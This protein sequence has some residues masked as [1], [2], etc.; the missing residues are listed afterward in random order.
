MSMSMSIGMNRVRG[1]VRLLVALSLFVGLE[2]A[3]PDHVGAQPRS[4]LKN[5]AHS[6]G[7][8]LVSG[9]C[10][11]RLDKAGLPIWRPMNQFAKDGLPELKHIVA[12]HFGWLNENQVAV[13][14][15]YL[16]FQKPAYGD[17]E[18]EARSHP[19][20]AN[21]CNADLR[22]VHL[23]DADLIR[24][25]LT[26]ANLSRANLLNANL[27]DANLYSANLSSAILQANMSGAHLSDANLSRAQLAGANL[28]RADLSEANLNRA[29][30]G[31][32]D[33]NGADVT[34][35]DLSHADLSDAN[36]SHANLSDANL[37]YANLVHANLSYANL[38]HANLNGA[39]LANADLTGATYAPNSEP[40]NPYVSGIRGLATV[41]LP[42]ARDEVGLVQL[43]K[44]LQD[45][46]LREEE[47]Q[48][49]YAIEH[50]N[51]SERLNRA[52]ALL[53]SLPSSFWSVI[54]SRAK[55]VFVQHDASKNG[56]M[57][58]RS[59]SGKVDVAPVRTSAALATVEPV[60]ALESDTT[61]KSSESENGVAV[62]FAGLVGAGSTV[63]FN[64]TTAYGMYPWLALVE[65]LMLWSFFTLVYMWAIVRASNESEAVATD[66]MK[67]SGI[68]QVF[69]A[70]RIELTSG[71]PTLKQE[72]R[73][74]IVRAQKWRNALR[75]AMYF[76]LLS[77]VNIGFEMF[78]PGDWVR[79]LQDCDYTL[80]AIGWVRRVSGVQALLSVALLALWVLTQF[81]RPFD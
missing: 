3:G 53:T 67:N 71:D 68:Y 40:P 17:W 13:D 20:Q 38:V 27:T 43:R 51:A 11:H 69:P 15:S 30:V 37:S 33:L 6:V 64:W 57:R 42:S 81:Q 25:N 9:I 23:N 48:V 22:D 46:A 35:A 34:G 1:Q 49:T 2:A 26:F 80:E 79:R 12:R 32:A 10:P 55:N 73:I 36:L 45:A 16:V 14:Y 63:A 52:R 29:D 7:E 47:R 24:A 56:E 44:L 41:Q 62:I 60:T 59:A 8:P 77:A 72:R 4:G 39:K 66:Q 76:S 31:R 5:W 74:V 21:L 28:S 50:A 78:T 70:D 75:P 19:A 18:R 58:S 65:I 61:P 54:W